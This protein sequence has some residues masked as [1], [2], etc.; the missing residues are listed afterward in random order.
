MRW[1]LTSTLPDVGWPYLVA[2]LKLVNNSQFPIFRR[3]SWVMLP[4]G[5]SKSVTFPFSFTVSCSSRSPPVSKGGSGG[6]GQPGRTFGNPP[7]DRPRRPPRR[8]T[9]GRRSPRPREPAARRRR[10]RGVGEAPRGP[11]PRP[12]LRRRM[13]RARALGTVGG[14]LFVKLGA[15]GEVAGH[16]V[17]RAPESSQDDRSPVGVRPG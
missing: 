16:L 5:T 6:I 11:G 2:G 10:S 15:R 7:R 13:S 14:D 12:A 3:S 9:N 1:K 17:G 4:F 8:R